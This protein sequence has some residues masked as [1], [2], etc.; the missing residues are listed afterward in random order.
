MIFIC[1]HFPLSAVQSPALPVCIL[2][3]TRDTRTLKSKRCVRGYSPSRR[4]QCDQP[5][6]KTCRTVGTWPQQM[7]L[8]VDEP[9]HQVSR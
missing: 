5:D 7:D 4:H 6:L 1:G 9:V 8:G 2:N 3:T